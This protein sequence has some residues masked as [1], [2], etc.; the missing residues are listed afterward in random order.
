MRKT[1]FLLL[2]I[3][4]I[5]CA[6]QAL[7]EFGMNDEGV[8]DG[9]LGDLIMRV[10]EIAVPE[11]GEYVTVWSG[12]QNMTVAVGENEFMSITYGYET[13]DPGS[14]PHVRVTVENLLPGLP[15]CIGIDITGE[16]ASQLHKIR[17]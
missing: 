14:Y 17:T 6:G 11:G 12:M 1:I 13:I 16:S 10:T 15:E 8:I 7:V 4:F 9:T 2:P 5:G 3:V